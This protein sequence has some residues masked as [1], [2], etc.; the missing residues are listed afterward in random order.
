MAYR[1]RVK[2][3]LKDKNVSIGKLSRGADIPI[4]LVR[5][6]VNDPTYN[7]SGE[8]LAKAARYLGVSVD[9]LIVYEEEK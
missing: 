1:L 3:V 5:R 9:D 2:E 7:P 6:M 4:T 8:T